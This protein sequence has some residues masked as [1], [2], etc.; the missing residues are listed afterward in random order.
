MAGNQQ[1]EQY[2]YQDMRKRNQLICSIITVTVVITLLLLLASSSEV[3]SS[4]NIM[5]PNAVLLIAVWTLHLARRFEKWISIVSI[6]GMF[7]ISI[8]SFIDGGGTTSK[9]LSAFFVLSIGLMYNSQKVVWTGFV[10]GLILIFTNHYIFVDDHLATSETIFTY[11]FYYL[12][13]STVLIAQS[14]LSRRMMRHVNSLS[15]EVTERLN[16]ELEREKVTAEATLTISNSIS[17]IRDNSQDN[18]KAF[19]EMNV[20]FQEM[21]SGATAQ[22]ETV[23]SISDHIYTSNQKVNHLFAQLDQLVGTVRAAKQ[24]SVD[25]SDVVERLTGTI[26]V[27]NSNMNSMI[28]EIGALVA[29]IHLI[30]EL[31]SSIQEIAS[32]TSLLSL[33]ASIEAARAGEQ[34]RGFEVV[35]QEIR[36]LAELTNGSAAQITENIGQATRQADLSQIR[37]EENVVSMKQSLLLVN[38]TQKAF[39]SI[40]HSVGE[41]ASGASEI[42]EVTTSVK[43]STEEIERSISDFVAV[44]E[45][46]SATLQELLATVDNLTAQN[47]PLVHRIEQTDQAVKQLI[48]M[49]G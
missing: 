27:F 26:D 35:A 36:K 10:A 41:L 13:A 23:G 5:I 49:E 33:N 34:G 12:L 37:L 44:V 25:G 8:V 30:S 20:A 18:Q 22:T 15:E 29:N 42:A 3:S 1:Q 46:S 43:E 31:T 48:T 19:Q 38:Q 24:S 7:V 2:I 47:Q 4:V 40:T 6:V 21:A 45:Q 32:Q 11:M 14:Y 9:V 39:Q 28:E 17:E 16:K